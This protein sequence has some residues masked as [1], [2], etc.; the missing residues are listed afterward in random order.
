M[1]LKASRWEEGL[2]LLSK[3]DELLAT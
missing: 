3:M 2:D 1:D